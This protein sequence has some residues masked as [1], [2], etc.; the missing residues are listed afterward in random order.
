MTCENFR[1]I[2][3]FL[4]INLMEIIGK[5]LKLCI[6]EENKI[7]NLFLHLLRSNFRP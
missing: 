1:K 2:N 7:I 4:I 3:K 6:L 5:T